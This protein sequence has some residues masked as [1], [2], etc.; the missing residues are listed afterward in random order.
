MNQ[1]NNW[2]TQLR[3]WVPRGPSPRLKTWLFATPAAGVSRDK[4]VQWLV[5]A[6]AAVLVLFSGIT[7]RPGGSFDRL[8]SQRSMLAGLSLS[9][10]NQAATLATTGSFGR[11]SAYADTYE[12][13]NADSSAATLISFSSLKGT[14]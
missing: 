3:S 9:N 5:P 1:M 12:W 4:G 11:N 6:M 13:T 14:K 8:P 7:Y 10:H 2:E